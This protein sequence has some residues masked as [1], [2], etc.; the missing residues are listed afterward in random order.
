MWAQH[1]RPGRTPQLYPRPPL[2]LAQR[3]AS[4]GLCPHLENEKS[5]TRLPAAGLRFS[6]V[7]PAARADVEY[8]EGTDGRRDTRYGPSCRIPLGFEKH[9]AKHPVSLL[10]APPLG[11]AA[12]PEA[13]G[14]GTNQ[15]SRKWRA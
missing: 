7:T 10:P 11:L 6:E 3:F 5:R 9:H 1:R 2:T 14:R 13:E 4:L 15:P 12:P 8:G